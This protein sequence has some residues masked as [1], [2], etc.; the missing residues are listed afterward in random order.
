MNARPAAPVLSGEDTPGTDFDGQVREV[1]R[2]R[3]KSR[4]EQELIAEEPGFLRQLQN[5]RVRIC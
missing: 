2:E 3:P 5:L 1:T 4:P